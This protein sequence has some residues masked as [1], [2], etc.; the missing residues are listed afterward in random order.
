MPGAYTPLQETEMRPYA[1]MLVETK[2]NCVAQRDKT[3]GQVDLNLPSRISG[4]ASRQH[5][6]SMVKKNIFLLSLV[7]VL[8]GI[9][10]YYFTGLFTRFTIQIDARPRPLPRGA[11][12]VVYPV[13]FSLDQKY[14]LTSVKVFP[15]TGKVVTKLTPPAWALTSKSNSVP[16]KGFIYG[17]PIPGMEPVDPKASPAALK[18]NQ[19]YRLLVESGKL[20]GQLDFKAPAVPKAT[21]Q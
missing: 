16:T 18:P 17:Q 20:K 9:Y 14:R 13:G 8:F 4:T 1:G 10:L 21:A 6:L 2:T 11:R 3:H 5:S 7:V 19:V 12:A 15:L